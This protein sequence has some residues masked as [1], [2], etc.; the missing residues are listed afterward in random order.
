MEGKKIY[1]KNKSVIPDEQIEML[2]MSLM[3]SIYDYWE[4]EEGQ[5]AYN[6]FRNANESKCFIASQSQ[7]DLKAV[8][9]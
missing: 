9:A 8:S 2:A 4:S 5:K 7:T 3:Q 1:V 6:D